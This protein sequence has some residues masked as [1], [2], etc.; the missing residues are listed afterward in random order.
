M[1]FL[2]KHLSYKHGSI[3]DYYPTLIKQPHSFTNNEDL[4]R[5]AATG[6]YI[7]VVEAV[8]NG[9][10]TNYKAAYRFKSYDY[11]KMAGGRWLG[12]YDYKNTSYYASHIGEYFKEPHLINSGELDEWIREKRYGM[13]PI[14]S[15]LIPLL[16][17]LFD[18]NKH[19]T[20]E[21]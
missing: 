21:F 12:A 8:K 9:T 14:P 17:R 15:E 19:Q 18:D 3:K 7:Y 16:N 13:R 20:V 2:V 1:A 11:H 4:A 10:R 6:N 5:A